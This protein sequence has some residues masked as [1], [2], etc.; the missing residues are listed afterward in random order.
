M[1]STRLRADSVGLKYVRDARRPNI[2]HQ[3]LTKINVGVSFLENH[4]SVDHTS[5][6]HCPMGGNGLISWCVYLFGFSHQNQSGLGSLSGTL[7]STDQ[8]TDKA[9]KVLLGP[10][11]M[12]PSDLL[13]PTSLRLVYVFNWEME[14]GS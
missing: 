5:R 12:R 4:Q 1:I 9:T 8:L 6:Y 10:R 7:V 3:R 14:D 13:P 2:P 11:A